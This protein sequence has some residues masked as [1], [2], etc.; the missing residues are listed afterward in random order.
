MQC[1]QICNWRVGLYL[2]NGSQKRGKEPSDGLEP[3]SEGSLS[4]WKKMTAMSQAVLPIPLF[5]RNLQR[6]ICSTGEGKSI[7]RRI[8][9]SVSRNHGGVGNDEWEEPPPPTG[10]DNRVRRISN[11]MGAVMEGSQ[12]GDPWT[13]EEC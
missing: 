7:I 12:M 6:P 10:H 1:E 9:L 11:R 4:C 5:Y 8:L 2:K 3:N 13:A